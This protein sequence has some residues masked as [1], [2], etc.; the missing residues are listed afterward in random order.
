MKRNPHSSPHENR[1][2]AFC[3]TAGYQIIH[4]WTPQDCQET[5]SF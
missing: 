4:Q 2:M 1:R 3:K 5:Y